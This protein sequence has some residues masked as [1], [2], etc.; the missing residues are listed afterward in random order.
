MHDSVAHAFLSRPV[1][2]APVSIYRTLKATKHG[3]ESVSR[4][5]KQPIPYASTSNAV[6][7]VARNSA[8]LVSKDKHQP[9][10]FI[11]A[12]RVERPR[13]RE[14]LRCRQDT[15][16]GVVVTCRTTRQVLGESIKHLSY[17]VAR[18]RL[19][20]EHV[21]ENSGCSSTFGHYIY[22]R[23]V[24]HSHSTRRP[25]GMLRVPSRIEDRDSRRWG[26]SIVWSRNLIL[27]RMVDERDG[28]GGHGY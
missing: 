18:H 23:R 17:S 1:A 19:V 28:L 22:C 7:K 21:H 13:V 5:R 11:F 4:M 16:A 26:R 24:S 10:R 12:S 8:G 25:R 15:T 14:R 2:V 20:L 9:S 6:E 27:L 3:T